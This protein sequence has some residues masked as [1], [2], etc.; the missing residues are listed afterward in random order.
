M[1]EEVHGPEVQVQRWVLLA[2]TGE[3][4]S[5]WKLQM[6]QTQHMAPLCGG[7][8]SPRSWQVHS[9][10]SKCCSLWSQTKSNDR[11][12]CV[13]GKW[14]PDLHHWLIVSLMTPLLNTWCPGLKDSTEIKLLNEWLLHTSQQWL[15][16]RLCSFFLACV[17]FLNLFYNK[18]VNS[19]CVT[20][21]TK[22]FF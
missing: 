20:F 12:F 10:R 4:A 15:V 7:K 8:D 19:T 2:D 17:K 6:K 1:A 3:Y 11:D 16:Y 18:K 22:R 21:T 9:F 14:S 13:G 5:D